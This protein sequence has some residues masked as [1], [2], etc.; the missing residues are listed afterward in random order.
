[1][2]RVLLAAAVA[3]FLA[4]VATVVTDD[5]DGALDQAAAER[6]GRALA[7]DI[8][9]DA[10]SSS[11]RVEGSAW[12]VNVVIE[13]GVLS[14]TTRQADGR[15]LDVAMVDTGGARSLERDS[16]LRVFERGC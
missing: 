8:G 15:I 4:G 14:F 5:G 3:V 1:V 9:F 12:R 11:A 16:R 6:C 7:A 13:G 2:T 10:Q